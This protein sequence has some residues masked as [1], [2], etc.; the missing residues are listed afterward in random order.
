MKRFSSAV[1][2]RAAIV[3]AL[4][5]ALTLAFSAIAYLPVQFRPSEAL[6][7]LPLLFVD[8]IPGL[9]V[10]CMIANLASAYGIWDIC[11]GSLITLIAALGTRLCR[12]IPNRVLAVGL[13]G[14][15][16][17]ALNALLLPLLWKLLGY[18]QGYWIN[19]G[20]MTASQLLSVYPLGIVLYSA[21]SRLQ[22]KGNPYFADAIDKRRTPARNEET[23]TP[24]ETSSDETKILPDRS[25][26]PT[27]HE[28]QD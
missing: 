1:L 28:H 9:F 2:C 4:Y 10:G 5:A 7:L 18:E 14:L 11:I 8:S 20:T 17:V 24:Q 12:R 21:L 23:P 15:F 13:G 6:T 3:A 25:D 16:P 19:V 27:S 22:R 26:E